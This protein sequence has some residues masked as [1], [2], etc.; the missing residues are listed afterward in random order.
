MK[1]KISKQH[2]E[3]FNRDWLRQQIESAGLSIYALAEKSG[4]ARKLIYDHLAGK[5]ELGS[6]KL[7]RLV[8]TL[9]NTN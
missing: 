3:P 7:G 8:E 1:M 5:S 6:D 9:K 4:I 2:L